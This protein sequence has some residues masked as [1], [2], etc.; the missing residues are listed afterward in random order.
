MT[1]TLTT[2]T[3]TLDCHGKPIRVLPLADLHLG[4]AHC[5]RG[6]ILAT[7]EA[8]MQD[9]NLYVI[10]DGDLM[11]S[12]I[13]G[14]KSD[15]Y[16]ETMS[17]AAQLEECT[18]LFQPLADAGKIL[19]ILPGNH[20][21]RISKSVGVDMT[22]I[23]ARQLGIEHLYSPTSAVIFLKFGVRHR[24]RAEGRPMVYSIYVTHGYGGGGRRAGGKVNALED[25][26]RIVDADIY[27]MGHT[28]QP[29]SFR[30]GHYVCSHSACAATYHEMVFVNTAAYLTY[31]GSYGDRM[32]YAPSSTIAP[33]ITLCDTE[34]QVRVTV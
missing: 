17:P 22:R 30:R 32:G 4:D 16:G 5:D 24:R 28:H 21:E 10:L 11:N 7:L 20:E 12:A 19:A 34:H 14:S 26:S 6:L 31:P 23:L 13:V 15:V 18:R 3:H 33:I 8:V 9:D 2:I 1:T 29:A 27:V 25:L